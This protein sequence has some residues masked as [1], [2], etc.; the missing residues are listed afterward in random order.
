RV[1]VSD[2]S[3]DQR[4]SR[5]ATSAVQMRVSRSLIKISSSVARNT[6]HWPAESGSSRDCDCENL[7]TRDQASKRHLLDTQYCSTRTQLSEG[8]VAT[9]CGPLI[10]IRPA[11]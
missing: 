7:R 9:N 11:N 10:V 5:A 1:T 6:I 4:R 2:E 3:V 8:R